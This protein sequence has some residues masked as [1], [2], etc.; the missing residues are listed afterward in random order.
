ML[1]SSDGSQSK[2]KKVRSRLQS[3]LAD[4]KHTMY[5]QIVTESRIEEAPRLE[6]LQLQKAKPKSILM[7]EPAIEDEFSLHSLELKRLK[8]FDDKAA[9]KKIK[10]YEKVAVREIRKDN[11]VIAKE[12][13]RET[14]LR[15]D[16]ARGKIFK[17]GNGPKDELWFN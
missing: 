4:Q 9:K 10:E 5:P 15:K 14:K 8:K 1:G 3:Y 7:L 11:L 13:A 2:L 12:R 6:Y 16:V 17:G